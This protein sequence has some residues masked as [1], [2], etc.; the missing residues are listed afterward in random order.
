MNWIIGVPPRR[1]RSLVLAALPVLL[2]VL[3]AGCA[4]AGA[5][6]GGSSPAAEQ[7]AAGG[8]SGPVLNLGDQ[9]QDLETLLRVVGCAGRRPLQGQLHRVRQRPAGRRRVRRAPDRRRVHGRPAR[10]AGGQVRAAG[11]GRR[12]QRCRS[13]P[14]STCW[15]S[16]ASPSIAQLRGKPVAY[17]TGTAEQAFALRALKTAGPDP[18]RRPPGQRQPA[19][20]R[21]GAGVG[22]R[23]R[24]GG[25]RRAE[26][27]LP[28]DPPGRQGAGHRRH[29]HPAQLR[30]PARHHG[31]AGQPGQA[32]RHRRLHQAADQGRELGED[33]P[34]PVGHRLLRQRR[35]PDAGRGEADPRRRRHG[36]LR[37]HHRRGAGRAA[38]RGQPDGRRPAPAHGLQRRPALQPSRSPALQRHPQEV[39]QNG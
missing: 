20:A 16:P 4:S 13:A 23:R 24:V 15:P 28:A 11:Q 37:A 22:R 2:A 25:Q 17:T 5:S 36:H 38:G 33:P 27:R 18:A 35:A 7:A 34:E 29:G 26:G 31:R 9:Q 32:G 8:S 1:P 6:G 12:R 39:P 3:L 10:L 30:L 21:H 19:A 14:R